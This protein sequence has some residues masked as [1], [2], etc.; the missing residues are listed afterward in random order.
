VESSDVS[1]LRRWRG[2]EGDGYNFARPHQSL[3]VDGHK[4]TPAMSA[5]VAERVWSLTDIAGLLD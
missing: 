1:S 5:G 4:R 3:T 2:R